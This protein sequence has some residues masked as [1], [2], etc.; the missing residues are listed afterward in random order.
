MNANLANKE[1]KFVSQ[2]N[3][4]LATKMLMVNLSITLPPLQLALKMYQPPPSLSRGKDAFPYFPDWCKLD[5]YADPRKF[6]PVP[7]FFL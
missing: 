3:T 1:C 5:C 6:Q 2:L 7:W 4:A